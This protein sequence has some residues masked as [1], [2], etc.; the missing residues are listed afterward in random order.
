M[1]ILAIVSVQFG[2][3]SAFFC[4]S[5]IS[6]SS[7]SLWCS[8]VLDAYEQLSP[9]HSLEKHLSADLRVTATAVLIPTGLCTRVAPPFHHDHHT[10][11]QLRTISIVSSHNIV[12]NQILSLF[13]TMI[14]SH[15]CD[16]HLV[17]TLTV[18]SV[19]PFGCEAFSLVD[20]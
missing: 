8:L 5:R 7:G 11:H 3:A 12:P 2:L 20:R 17:P 15:F 1:R 9:P 14:V 13:S 6:G 10:E 16:N 19:G 18:V 4:W